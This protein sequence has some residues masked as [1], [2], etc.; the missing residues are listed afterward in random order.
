MTPYGKKVIPKKGESKVVGAKWRRK[1]DLLFIDGDHSEKAVM[2]DL[3]TWVKHVKEGGCILL[4]DYTENCGVR[5]AIDKYMKRY[6]LWPYKGKPE[7]IKTI[8]SILH[9]EL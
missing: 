9:I 1:I 4:H 2:S 8:G 5:P 7:T 3:K 6:W